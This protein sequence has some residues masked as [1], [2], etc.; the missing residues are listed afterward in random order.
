MKK[1]LF[2]LAVVITSCSVDNPVNYD[3]LEPGVT[4]NSASLYDELGISDAMN[5]QLADGKYVITDSLLVYNQAGELV[6]KKGMES[7]TM[8]KRTLNLDALPN[9]TYTLIL[10]Q[11]VIRTADDV[12][13]WVVREEESLSTVNV[14]S[15]GSPM[16]Y[17]WALG[18]ATATVT[19]NEKPIK[20]KMTP[21]SQGCILD[22]FIDNLTED[23][24]YTR[25]AMVS[26]NAEE[27]YMG[28]YMDPNR[29]GAE[30]WISNN[31]YIEVPFRIY[32]NS[33]Y[34]MFFSLMHGD[35]LT[36]YIRGDKTD[37]F[38]DLGPIPHKKVTAGKKYM[39]Y[40]D[41]ARLSYQPP[42]FGSQKD[43]IAWKAD[44]YKGLLVFDP[45]LK[46]GCK[47]SEVEQH[48][49]AKSWWN[50]YR[51]TENETEIYDYYQVAQNLYEVYDF[52][53]ENGNTLKSVY[54]SCLDSKVTIEDANALL[55]KQGYVY[56]GKIKFP[57]RDDIQDLYFSADGNIEVQIVAE[58]NMWSYY[59]QPTDPDDFQ[60]II[61]QD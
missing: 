43:L 18:Y 10:W 36:T 49:K 50:Y 47:A 59:Y 27:W 34:G 54:C 39:V 3:V 38:D 31:Q 28:F 37:G 52:D 46:W 56:K 25:I 23:L 5:K 55:L 17:Q 51:R 14:K 6:A 24:G 45:C 16:S 20:V 35:D 42:F 8:G 9:G 44:R 2:L 11:A 57:N 19:V 53:K 15:P 29:K 30:R 61:P 60:Y 48:I 13:A 4:F 32:T 1:L 41:L 7:S 22:V 21:K 40:I 12:R 33:N 58:D 26:A